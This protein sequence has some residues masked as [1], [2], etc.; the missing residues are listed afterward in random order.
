MIIDSQWIDNTLIAQMDSR[1]AAFTGAFGGWTAALAIKT[2]EQIAP[3]N[4]HAVSLSIEFLRG[5]GAGEVTAKPT[6]DRAGRSIA[7]TRVEIHQDGMA[8]TA[9]VAFAAHRDTDAVMIATQ[10]ECLPP[11]ALEPMQFPVDDVTWARE[12]DMRPA[13]GRLLQRNDAL[14]TLIWTRRSDRSALTLGGLFALADASIPRIFFHYSTP[15]PIATISMTTYRR[16]TLDHIAA[17]ADDFVLVE[18]NCDSVGNGFFDHRLKLWSRT[19][20]LLGTST[21][22]ASFRVPAEA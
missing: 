3:P 1:F 22:L 20:V 13:T 17:V 5:V 21:Q 7:F 11:E 16:A 15:S 10:P 4:M 8:A 14:R 6:L 2:A 19:G 9:S 18:A 12:Y